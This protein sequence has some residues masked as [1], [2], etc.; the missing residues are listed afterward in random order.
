MYSAG[1]WVE[2]YK[3]LPADQ[4]SHIAPTVFPPTAE[5]VSNFHLERW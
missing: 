1:K 2:T 3:D 4:I 5:E